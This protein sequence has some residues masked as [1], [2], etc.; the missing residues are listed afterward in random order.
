MSEADQLLAQQASQTTNLMRAIGDNTQR[1]FDNQF[2][3]QAAQMTTGLQVAGQIEQY[4]MNDAKLTELNQTMRIRD[5]QHQWE[6]VNQAFTERLQPLQFQAQQYDLQNK[7]R[8]Q[9]EQRMSPF[10]TDIKGEFQ[11]LIM[12]S[13][14][15]AA[16]A[17]SI[18]ARSIDGVLNKTLSDPNADIASELE[19]NKASMRSWI[20]KTKT[21]KELLRDEINT[22][23]KVLGA[24]FNPLE[25]FKV[26][27]KSAT[28]TTDQTSRAASIYSTTFGGVPQ[29]FLR[30]HD[31]LYKGSSES[32]FKIMMAS[33]QLTSQEDYAKLTPEQQA[34]VADRIE[35]KQRGTVMKDTLEEMQKEI[36]NY[37]DNNAKSGGAYSTLIDRLREQRNSMQRVYNKEILGVDIIE[38]AGPSRSAIIEKNAASVYGSEASTDGV[39]SEVAARVAGFKDDE[40]PDD[41]QMATYNRVQKQLKPYWIV[42]FLGGTQ[43]AE[44]LKSLVES[45]KLNSNE[46]AKL[47]DKSSEVKLAALAKSDE[48][49]RFVKMSGLAVTQSGISSNIA[50]RGA[51]VPSFIETN[52]GKAIREIGSSESTPNQKKNA[53]KVLK[54]ELPTAIMR[55][56][57]Q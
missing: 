36:D 55:Y 27:E 46:V 47:I 52:L 19:K 34:A 29:D 56:T 14:E 6:K 30:K 7:F 38:E 15:L 50:A 1:A 26:T 4:R 17:Q 54:K 18:Y 9:A 21:K 20:E 39:T 41:A 45:D 33:G 44:T 2:R 10:L 40:L 16:E 49:S 25:R 48:F 42:E 22:A 57:T 13:P 3:V 23:N 32:A 35:K 53:L 37:V 8:A 31:T 24:R 11:Q 51:V 12:D 28:L 5:Q 43:N